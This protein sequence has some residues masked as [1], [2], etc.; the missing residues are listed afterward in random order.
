MKTAV[1][2]A[3]SPRGVMFA[4]V[5]EKNTYGVW[6]LDNKA[7]KPVAPKLNRVEAFSIFNNKVG[8]VI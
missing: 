5:V 6:K 3:V 7:W 1:K 2:K 4:V 8:G